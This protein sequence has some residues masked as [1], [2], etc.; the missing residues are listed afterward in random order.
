MI[1]PVAVVLGVLVLYPLVYGVYLSL[2]DADS[3]NSARTIGVNHIEATYQFIGLDNYADILWGDTAYDRFWSHFIW[4]IVWT[5][6]CV[7]LHYGIGLGLALLLNQKLRGRT[8]YRLVLVLPWAVPTFVTVFGW[9]FMLADGG[10]I[11]SALETLHLPAP[12]WLHDTLRARVP[13]TLRNT[14]GGR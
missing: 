12:D 3:L 4:T 6:L 8:L 7:A 13:A 14:Q 5:A 2:T 11:N 10:I 1:A 9:R